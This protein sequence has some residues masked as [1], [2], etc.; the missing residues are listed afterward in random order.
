MR[1]N[2]IEPDDAVPGRCPSKKRFVARR[3]TPPRE[4]AWRRSFRA[5]PATDSAG[6]VRFHRP[7]NN[8]HRRETMRHL[9]VFEVDHPASQNWKRERVAA[10]GLQPIPNLAYAP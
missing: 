1:P 9:T 2:I 6:Q 5:P 7:V 4:S 8:E 3:A 10:L